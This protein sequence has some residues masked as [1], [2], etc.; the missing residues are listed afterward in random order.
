MAKAAADMILSDDNFATI[1]TAVEEGRNIYSNMQTFVT[2]LI[3][4]NI[5]EIVVILLAT[6]IGLPGPLTPLHLLWINLGML[7]YVF[8]CFLLS[9]LMWL[10]CSFVYKKS[11]LAAD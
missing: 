7:S 11:H 3:S 9:S 2:F 10:I 6:L 5:G 8:I 4:C 1:V